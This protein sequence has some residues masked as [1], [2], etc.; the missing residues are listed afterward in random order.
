M[1]ENPSQV[2]TSTR[3]RWCDALRWKYSWG[4]GRPMVSS[5]WYQDNLD[6]DFV[7]EDRYGSIFQESNLFHKDDDNFYEWQSAITFYKENEWMFELMDFKDTCLTVNNINDGIFLFHD[8]SKVE[9][10][11]SVDCLIYWKCFFHFWWIFKKGKMQLK[12]KNNLCILW[13]RYCKWSNVSK[14][15]CEVSCW[16]FLIE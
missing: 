1:V 8:L 5:R 7:F 6:I 14:G 15:V 2:K 11:F 4:G 3:Q 12:Y 10:T 16:R 13:R 9:E